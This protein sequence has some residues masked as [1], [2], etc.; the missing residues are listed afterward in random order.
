MSG[1]LKNGKYVVTE[2]EK[3]LAA[4][5]R[6]VEKVTDQVAADVRRMHVIPYCDK[7]NLKFV[8]GMGM[9]MFVTTKDEIKQPS[10]LPKRLAHL[11]YA[12][13]YSKANS[14]GSLIQDYTPRGFKEDS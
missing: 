6:H 3:I 11:M 9:W 4:A 14:L 12:S 7:H 13:T 8:T 1:L 2:Y 5:M 10:T